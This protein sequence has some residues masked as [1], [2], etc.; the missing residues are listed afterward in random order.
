MSFKFKDRVSTHPNRYR[1]IP[2]S[3]SSYY[4]TF[5]RADGPTEVGTPINATVMNSVMTEVSRKL[6]VVKLWE[7]DKPTDTFGAQTISLDLSDCQMVAV[8]CRFSTGYAHKKMYFGVVGSQIGM[9]VIASSGNSGLRKATISATGI[10]F[11][12]AT[13]NGSSDVVGYIIPTEIYGIK[14]VIG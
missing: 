2:E 10:S 1:I 3:G 7:N 8:N 14:G 11:E 12:T 4:A 5:E 9:D 6:S 13:Y